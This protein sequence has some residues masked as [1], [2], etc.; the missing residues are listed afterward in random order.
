MPLFS[1]SSIFLAIPSSM[2]SLLHHLFF[3]SVLCLLIISSTASNQLPQVILSKHYYISD[4]FLCFHKRYNLS[5][6]SLDSIM[7]FIWGVHQVEMEEK[8]LRLQ[9]QV[10]CSC[11][12]PLYQGY[13]TSH[14]HNPSLYSHGFKGLTHGI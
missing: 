8:L 13:H 12:P 6:L 9:R 3:L 11:C 1:F 7:W 4:P 14:H 10:I 5:S 2:A